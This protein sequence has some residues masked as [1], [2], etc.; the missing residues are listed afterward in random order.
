MNQ[1]D[2]ALAIG[3]HVLKCF[4]DYTEK[5]VGRKLV[6]PVKIPRKRSRKEFEIIYPNFSDWMIAVEV[7]APNLIVREGPSN[8]RSISAREFF[9]MAS[10]LGFEI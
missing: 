9:K 6:V 10:K 8:F 4:Y 2:L 3:E 5:P 1:K 7:Q